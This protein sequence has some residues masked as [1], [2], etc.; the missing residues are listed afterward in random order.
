MRI[1]SYDLETTDLRAN[2]GIILCAS[3]QEIVPPGYY[4]NHHDTPPRPYT[5]KLEVNDS[6]RYDPDPDKELA[7]AIREELKKYNAAVCWN[8]KMFD[9]PFLNSRLLF[10]GEEPWNPQFHID[11]MYYAGGTSNRIGSRR[12]ASVQQ[13]LQLENEK[14]ALDWAIWKRAMRGDKAAMKEVVRHCEIDVG[15]LAEAY[16]R[17]L[18]FISNIHR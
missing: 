5:F 16:W 17:L 2:M 8:G 18:P 13:F 4:G 3:F 10:H 7:I 11:A 12:L 14:P 6:N 1:V 15:A 9:R